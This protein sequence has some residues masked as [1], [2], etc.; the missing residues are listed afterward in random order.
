MSDIRNPSAVTSVADPEN[1]ATSLVVT[2]RKTESFF[3]GESA[4]K[5]GIPDMPQVH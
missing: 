1:K 3:D 2:G 4:K 5:V